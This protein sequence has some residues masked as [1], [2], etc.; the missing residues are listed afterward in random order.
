[1]QRRMEMKINEWKA[2]QLH[3]CRSHIASRFY[4]AWVFEHNIEWGDN[5]NW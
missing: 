2:F 5:E 3:I 4:F 1:M